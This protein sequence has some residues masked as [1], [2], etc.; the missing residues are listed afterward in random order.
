[1]SKICITVKNC[2]E[3]EID[4]I[5]V[6]VAYKL[7]LASEKHFSRCIFDFSR[8]IQLYLYV[9]IH[10]GHIRAY[11]FI[12]SRDI[13]CP[14]F[15][16]DRDKEISHIVQTELTD[17]SACRRREVGG[18]IRISSSFPCYRIRDHV[19][20]SANILIGARNA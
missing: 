14:E 12:M 4:F 15:I 9:F 16:V 17:F 5:G 6:I 20:Q 3:L 18:L 7:F 11:P 2:T 13:L 19:E 8:I 1:M 10:M